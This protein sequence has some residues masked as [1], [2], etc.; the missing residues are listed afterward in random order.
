MLSAEAALPDGKGIEFF[1]SK[2][3]PVLV[4]KCLYLSFARRCQSEKAQR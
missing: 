4:S 3:R 1:E 2:I